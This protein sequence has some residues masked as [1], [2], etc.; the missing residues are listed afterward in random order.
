MTDT[1]I[2]YERF[3]ERFHTAIQRIKTNRESQLETLTKALEALSPLA[4]L[5]RGYSVVRRPTGD[6]VMSASSLKKDDRVDLIFAD[7]EVHARILD[8]ASELDNGS[9]NQF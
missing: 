6:M 9:S 2:R 3:E 7:G 5:T 4:V 1:G 8:S